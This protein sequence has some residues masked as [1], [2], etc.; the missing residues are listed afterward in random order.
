MNIKNRLLGDRTGLQVSRLALGTG[1][2]GLG[3]TTVD[4]TVARETIAA[5]LNAGGNLIDTSSRYLG[6][7]AETLVGEFIAGRRDEIVVI[8]KYGRTPL[9]RPAV[10]AAGQHRKALR[11][12]VEASLKRLNTDHIDVLLAHTDDGVTPIED[13][14]YGIEG[15]VREGK[16]LYFG[17]SSFPAW[18]AATA[19]TIADLRGWAP[20]VALEMHYN[21]LERAPEREHSPFA[22][23]RGLAMLA[24][25]PLSGGLLVGT[26]KLRYD[27]TGDMASQHR[28]ILEG[29]PQSPEGM[30]VR[31]DQSQDI[32]ESVG[33]IAR[34]AG[35]SSVAV[36]IAWLLS[37]GAI[38]VMGPRRPDQL[39]QNLDGQ[40]LVLTPEQLTTLDAVSARAQGFPYEML[41][42]DRAE[43]GLDL[44]DRR[45]GSTL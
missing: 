38:P 24:A 28:V 43:L 23:A 32:V 7:R 31:D 1:R 6:G 44:A 36:S 20:L 39:K 45:V 37:K 5:Y 27:I 33:T 11:A 2:I 8:S 29:G 15:L 25:A 10:S 34:A 41:D 18:R 42:V 21:L 13:L 16:V 22:A 40:D 3:G 12:E 17:L 35:T 26:M 4:E 14:M 9:A 19:A 30:I